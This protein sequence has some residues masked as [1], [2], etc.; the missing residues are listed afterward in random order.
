M[1]GLFI[2]LEGGD[3][4]G[5]TTHLGYVKD[6]FDKKGR[7]LIVTREPGGTAVGEKIRHILLHSE[8]G[9][10][11]SETEL[12]L[13][14]AARKQHVE[15]VILPD[16]SEGIS[17]LCDRFTDASF[18]YQGAGRGIDL[19]RILYL[20]NWIHGNLQPDLTLLFD[21][22]IETASER[23]NARESNDRF[24]SENAAFKERVRQGYLSRA[25]HSSE[26]MKLIDA[27]LSIEE[28][29]KDLAQVLDN[30]LCERLLT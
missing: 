30:L 22:D 28:I 8:T 15:E 5:K 29:H 13:M 16:L 23:A 17:V 14:F 7:P 26:R 2:T 27:S 1:S 19:Q 3:G 10:V 25:K 9:E 21:V 4:A 6:W 20:E 12:L 24:D 18:A 11:S